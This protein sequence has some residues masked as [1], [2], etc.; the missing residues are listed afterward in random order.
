M[1]V[2]VPPPDVV[3]FFAR[4]FGPIV[5]ANDALDEEGRAALRR[6]LVEVFERFNRGTDGTT[7]MEGEFL[8]VQAVC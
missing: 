2:S 1:D 8:S 4:H 5:R 6:D 3:D 7:V